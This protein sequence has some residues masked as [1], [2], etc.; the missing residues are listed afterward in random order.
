MFYT[1]QSSE[2]LYI[3]YVWFIGWNL[4]WVDECL[5]L[6]EG[7]PFLCKRQE[8]PNVPYLLGSEL[9]ELFHSFNIEVFNIMGL[10]GIFVLLFRLLWL[11][12]SPPIMTCYLTCKWSSRRYFST[13]SA[14]ASYKESDWFYGICK[15]GIEFIMFFVFVWYYFAGNAH[16]V[17]IT[18]DYF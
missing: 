14:I 10:R 17:C 15:A 18:V 3:C 2:I 11:G 8:Y 7:L 1:I 13:L 9:S 12:W 5:G 16:L 4:D 6:E